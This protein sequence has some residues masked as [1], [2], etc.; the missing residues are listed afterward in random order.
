MNNPDLPFNAEECL[1]KGPQSAMERKFIEEYLKGK[2]YTLKELKQLP[3]EQAKRLMR[4]ACTYASLKLTDV[5]AKAHFR[6]NIR[7]PS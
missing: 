6:R 1:S 7:F 3:E 4:E 5:E 2:G